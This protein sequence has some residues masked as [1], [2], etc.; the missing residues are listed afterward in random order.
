MRK[1]RLIFQKYN[2]HLVVYIATVFVSSLVA[3]VTIK[4]PFSVLF[5][6]LANLA[7]SCYEVSK[8]GLIMTSVPRLGHHTK[9]GLYGFKFQELHKNYYKH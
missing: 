7:S 5:V 2:W 4:T 3:M 6:I 9:F 8:H 1:Y